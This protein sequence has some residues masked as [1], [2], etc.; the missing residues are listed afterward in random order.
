MYLLLIVIFLWQTEKSFLLISLYLHQGS[1]FI[2][3]LFENPLFVLL[4]VLKL[5]YLRDVIRLFQLPS[6]YI[7]FLLIV[8]DLLLTFS[9]FSFLY[10]YLRIRRQW[11]ITPYLHRYLTVW[12]ADL[13]GF[14]LL[15]FVVIHFLLFLFLNEHVKLWTQFFHFCFQWVILT[16]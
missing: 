14:D 6:H 5:S 3:Q 8:L 12:M 13:L 10:L 1:I 11:S 7:N 9:Q 2:L 15:L 4:L 16:S